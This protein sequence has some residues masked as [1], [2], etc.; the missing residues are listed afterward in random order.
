MEYILQN[1]TFTNKPILIDNV[2]AI[3]VI[4]SYMNRPKSV[5]LGDQILLVIHGITIK[6][7]LIKKDDKVCVFKQVSK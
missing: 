1:P 2:K 3:K 6:L 7:N 5:I 4:N